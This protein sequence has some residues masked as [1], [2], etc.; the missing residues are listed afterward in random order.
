MDNLVA[1]HYSKAL[2]SVLLMLLLVAMFCEQ[3]TIERGI[4]FGRC[5][6]AIGGHCK[7]LCKKMIIIIMYLSGF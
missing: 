4:H 3:K 5:A 1:I 6:M 7:Y 2:G